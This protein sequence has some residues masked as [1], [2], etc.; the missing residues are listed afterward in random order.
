ML[1]VTP[2][3]TPTPTTE[4]AS[5]PTPTAAPVALSPTEAE[6]LLYENA[7]KVRDE[8]I[9]NLEHCR[10]TFAYAGLPAKHDSKEG[11]TFEGRMIM[12]D[13][14]LAYSGHSA[15]HAPNDDD[16][17]RVPESDDDFR[18]FDLDYDPV[19]WFGAEYQSLVDD[20]P[21]GAHVGWST[22][23][24]QPSLRYETRVERTGEQ[25]SNMPASALIVTDYLVE[26]PYVFVEREYSISANGDRRLVREFMRHRFELR[27]CT[28]GEKHAAAAVA[29][30]QEFAE[31]GVEVYKPLRE[32]LL[33]GC[34]MTFNEHGVQWLDFRGEAPPGG[35]IETEG[36]Y[37][38]ARDAEGL[39]RVTSE[40]VAKR[41]GRVVYAIR[42]TSEGTWTLDA[43]TGEWTEWH[44]ADN[45]GYEDLSDFLGQYFPIGRS[46]FVDWEGSPVASDDGQYYD[47]RYTGK[48]VIEGRAAA[49]YEQVSVHHHAIDVDEGL[50][51]Q[52]AVREF[53]EDNPLLSR[54][55]SYFLLP[56]GELQLGWESTIDELRLEDCP[57]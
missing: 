12:R 8:S 34:G 42:M 20:A 16:S 33:D 13:G 53:F 7:A 37:A 9:R 55:S 29:V 38:I 25:D 46:G 30:W 24:G 45:P 23:L 31:R 54:R 2:T 26:N 5:T 21:R 39:W 36:S 35:P 48:V 56:S 40:G 44:D 43:Q 6:A 10:F 51:F 3:L 57:G 11:W 49:R 52:I 19:E 17:A 47:R 27:D 32:G 41:Q 28:A 14:R 1:A 50:T 15:G 4:P 18:L 22:Y